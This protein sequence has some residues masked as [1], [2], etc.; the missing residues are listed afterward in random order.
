VVNPLLPKVRW[1]WVRWTFAAVLLVVASALLMVS[2]MTPY[3]HACS[4]VDRSADIPVPLIGQGEQSRLPLPVLACKPIDT[5]VVVP[6]GVVALLLLLPDYTE[7]AF[8]GVALKRLEQQITEKVDLISQEFKS[9]RDSVADATGIHKNP[10]TGELRKGKLRNVELRLESVQS[11]LLRI[12]QSGV[13]QP[14]ETLYKAGTEWG[15]SWSRDFAQIEGGSDISTADRIKSVLED[16]SYY[17]ATAGM[18]RIHFAYSDDGRPR[19][20][21]VHNGFLSI[22]RDGIDLRHLFGGYIAGSLNGIFAPQQIEFRASLLSKA[23]GTDVYKLEH[24][25]PAVLAS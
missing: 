15:E 22:E 2:N 10:E 21:R 23:V 17:D 16:W 19:E 14:A 18:G 12:L 13:E 9:I 3:L 1:T 8:G 5:W 24:S 4:S 25:R 11:I 6:I 7:I 20:A